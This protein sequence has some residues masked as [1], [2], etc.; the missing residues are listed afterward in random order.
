MKPEEEE[1]ERK[2]KKENEEGNKEEAKN[3]KSFISDRFN[4]VSKMHIQRALWVGGKTDHMK[5][6]LSADNS[7]EDL[8]DELVRACTWISDEKKK[9]GEGLG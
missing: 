6:I 3:C 4:D 8:A 9:E 1:V 7:A 2:E 5:T